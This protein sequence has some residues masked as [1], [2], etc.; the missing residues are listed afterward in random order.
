[1]NHRRRDAPVGFCPACGA[2]VNMRAIIRACD[3]P[4]HAAARLR[5]SRYCVDC[6]AQLIA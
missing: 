4:K 5:Q 3:E 6:G 1:M 2:V